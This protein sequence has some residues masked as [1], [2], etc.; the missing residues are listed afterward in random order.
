MGAALRACHLVSPGWLPGG[1]APVSSTARLAAACRQLEAPVVE[2]PHVESFNSTC[3]HQ[4]NMIDR[5][6]KGLEDPI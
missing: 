3:K 2:Q 5:R 6:I 4:L 1:M